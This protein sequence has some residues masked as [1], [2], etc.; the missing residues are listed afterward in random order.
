M[1]YRRV[2]SRLERRALL[3]KQRLQSCGEI[4][5]RLRLKLR[6]AELSWNSCMLHTIKW[7]APPALHLPRWRCVSKP[8]AWTPMLVMQPY[9][10]VRLESSWCE[11]NWL[12]H[13]S[14]HPEFFCFCPSHICFSGQ[15]I[16][17]ILKLAMRAYSVLSRWEVHKPLSLIWICDAI[18]GGAHSSEKLCSGRLRQST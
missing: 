13:Q 11:Y 1:L 7:L 17:Q 15:G 18:K 9:A 10:W 8:T 3:Y 14:A 2:Q 4:L 12:I 5:G 6:N 16:Q